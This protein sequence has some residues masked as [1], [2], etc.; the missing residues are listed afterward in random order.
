MRECSSDHGVQV[1]M[2]R[3]SMTC[4][5]VPVH[6]P[7]NWAAVSAVAGLLLAAANSDVSAGRQSVMALL[8]NAWQHGLS[9]VGCPSPHLLSAVAKVLVHVMSMAARRR[10][11]RRGK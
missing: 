9:A 10:A 6:K 3:L 1:C 4:R 2:H 11:C 5:P 8:V 7:H